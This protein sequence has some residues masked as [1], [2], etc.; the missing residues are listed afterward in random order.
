M[1]LLLALAL[2]FGRAGLAEAHA[3]LLRSNPAQD[4]VLQKAPGEIHLWFSEDLDT[5]ASRV[6]V[7]DPSHHNA[8]SSVTGAPG[9][10]DQLIVHLKRH[11]A[12]GSY[13]VLWT[14]V[15]ATDGHI[16]HGYYSFGIKMM[17]PGANA[18]AMAQERSATAL[19]GIGTAGAVIAHW[20]ELLAAVTWVGALVFS[21]L[22]IPAA[23]RHLH[24]SLVE[25]ERTRMLRLLRLSLL[26]LGYSSCA[27]ALCQVLSQATG[28]SSVLSGSTW[29][30]A[31]AVQYG[32][33]WIARQVMVILAVLSTFSFAAAP[34]S[35]FSPSV[36]AMARPQTAPWKQPLAV[37]AVIGLLYLYLLAGSGHAASVA[38]GNVDGSQLFSLSVGIDWLH[39]LAVA[40]W[41]GGQIYI[42]L[43]L[44]PA[45]S[46]GRSSRHTLQVFLDTLNRFSPIAYFCVAVFTFSGAFVGKVHFTS[47]YQVFS[48]TYGRAL[49]VKLVLVGMM[50]MTSAA[51]V[52][53]LRPRLKR[54]M[55]PHP[56]D[57][58]I[59][60]QARMLARGLAVNPVLGVGVLLATSVMFY[61]PVDPGRPAAAAPAMPTT[62]SLAGGGLHLALSLQSSQAGTNRLTVRLLDGHKR[63]ISQASITAMTS[64]PDMNSGN[65][66][67]ALHQAA[68]GVFSGPA[69]L[70]LAGAW[71]VQLLVYRP[72]GLTRLSQTIRIGSGSAM[73]AMQPAH[74]MKL[75]PRESNL[76]LP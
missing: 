40:L 30:Q 64:M 19:S 67:M 16:L 33:L 25:A 3:F 60:S 73:M 69:Q 13:V 54:S 51:T 55:W 26:T 45:L 41:F 70:P 14:S 18:A 56:D 24:H 53:I 38:I 63:P 61:N 32:H 50:M 43:V 68:P 37:P 31:F 8:V 35:V 10:S 36:G 74:R 71:R 72:S 12:T 66:T 5:A 21:V 42:A 23:A 28:W 75:T 6:V 46:V 22:L 48:T 17:T 15:S 65:L 44:I 7:L 20:I 59:S 4:T 1:P 27:V 34:A 29:D 9:H 76:L 52:Y 62:Y 2:L 11:L 58:R 47:W 57:V 49:M 39:Y